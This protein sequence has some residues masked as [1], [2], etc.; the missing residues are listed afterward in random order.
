MYNEKG[1]K[2]KK[3]NIEDEIQG[4]SVDPLKKKNKPLGLTEEIKIFLKNPITLEQIKYILLRLDGPISK[5]QF[6]KSNMKIY[7]FN[8]YDK[9]KIY[10]IIIRIKTKDYFITYFLNS[11]GL[12]RLG[13]FDVEQNE[14]SPLKKNLSHSI[15]NWIYKNLNICIQ[16]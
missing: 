9:Q 7:C 6:E 14:K 12:Y 11:F 16:I 13:F 3:I 5:F 10:E 4:V 2:K 8:R 1:N 15:R